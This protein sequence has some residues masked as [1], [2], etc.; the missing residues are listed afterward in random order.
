MKRKEIRVAYGIVKRLSI[1]CGCSEVTVR[2]ALRGMQDT[3]K[4]RLVRDRAVRFYGGEFIT[5]KKPIL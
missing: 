2:Y 4:S 1:D 3:E 5:T